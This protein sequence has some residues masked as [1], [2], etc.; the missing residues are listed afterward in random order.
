MAESGSLTCTKDFPSSTRD[1]LCT[2][3]YINAVLVKQ[4]SVV[5]FALN[6]FPVWIP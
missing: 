6:G 3:Q 4:L 5:S 2:Q 1:T